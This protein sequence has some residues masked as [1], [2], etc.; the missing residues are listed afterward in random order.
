MNL[1]TD[2]WLIAGM[3]W[4]PGSAPYTGFNGVKHSTA[5]TA[6][7]TIDEDCT[8]DLRLFDLQEGGDFDGK[9]V[10]LIATSTPPDAETR[11]NIRNYISAKY[12]LQDI[13]ETVVADINEP[14]VIIVAKEGGDYT[15]IQSAF[16]SITDASS[17]NRYVVFLGQGAVSYTHLTL[18]TK[19]IV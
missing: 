8:S 4:S 16:D 15:S 3:T 10:E 14:N 7:T 13:G 9:I 12:S 1:P 19:R 2:V 6:V 18:P 17:T 11:Q 5:G